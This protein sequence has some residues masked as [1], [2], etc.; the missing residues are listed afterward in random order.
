MLRPYITTLQSRCLR[1]LPNGLLAALLVCSLE[2]RRK[3]YQHRRRERRRQ[4]PETSPLRER[5]RRVAGEDAVVHVARNLRADQHPDSIRH[6]HEEALRL[7]AHGRRRLLV[8]V[9]LAR[10]KEEV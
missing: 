6:E 10:D 1:L 5:Q 2:E 4:Y 8:D 9:D 3:E 7:A